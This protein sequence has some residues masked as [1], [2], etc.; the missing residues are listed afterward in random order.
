MVK[1]RF[2]SDVELKEFEEEFKHFLIANG[3]H[4]EEWEKLNN[5]NPDRAIEIVGLFSDLILDKV[6]DKTEFLIHQDTKSIKAF[7]FFKENAVLIGVDYKGEGD[8]PENDILKFLSEN[9]ADMLIYAT[10]KTFSEENRNKE[11]HFLVQHG[12]FVTSHEV[13]D[14]LSKVKEEQ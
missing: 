3:V 1:Y 8:L 12:A 2:L 4:A 14:Y 13:F 11:L 9:A 6:Y 10:S 7:K 5:E